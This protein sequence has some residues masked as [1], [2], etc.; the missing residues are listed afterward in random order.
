MDNVTYRK[1]TKK[2]YE[3]VKELICDAFR[4]GEF[5]ED[6]KFLDSILNIYLHS[7]I[8]DSSFSKVAEK[9]NKVIG[10][11]LGSAKKD[12]NR[13]SKSH[14]ILVTASAFFKLMI[15]SKENKKLFKEFLKIQDIYK[16]IIQGKQDSLQGCVHLFIISKESRGL[17][18]G[19]TLINYLSNYMQSM[20]VESMYLYT[21]TRCNYGFYDSQNFKRLNEKEIYLDSIQEKLNI[22]LYGYD[23]N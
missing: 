18:V 9:D 2:D 17:G 15:S 20:E 22:F 19:K 1:L 11:I 4:F 12:K 3:R 5:I 6:K 13:L 8:L 23:F 21:D 14:S 10:V 7:C 16:E